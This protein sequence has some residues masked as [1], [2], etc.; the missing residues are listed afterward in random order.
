MA[1]GMTVRPPALP[2]RADGRY[3][4]AFPPDPRRA[5]ALSMTFPPITVL[6]AAA[7]ALAWLGRQGTRAI[8]GVVLVG[9]AVPPLGALLR[10]FVT[11]AIFVL[12]AIAFTRVDAGA[13]RSYLRRP[14]MVIAAT[15][16]TM[17]AVPL[18]F[19]VVCLLGGLDRQAPEL[20]LAL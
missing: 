5:P 2:G 8:A 1:K 9:I 20:F 7:A 17:L 11:A 19:G 15:A 4:S 10:P 16:W 14:A 18:L 6:R 3:N 13:L 12:L